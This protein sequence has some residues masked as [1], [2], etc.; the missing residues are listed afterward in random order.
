M[1]HAQIFPLLVFCLIFSS[2]SFFDPLT[3]DKP[4][5]D[6]PEAYSS[7][8]SQREEAEQ[9]WKT[10]NDPELDLLIAQALREN[11]SLKEAWA[12]LRQAQALAVKSGADLYPEVNLNTEIGQGRQR[13]KTDA[14]TSTGSAENYTLGLASTY[15]L[16][17]WGR[18]RSE[19]QAARLSASASREDVRTAAMTLAASVAQ[20]WAG[21]VSMRMQKDLLKKQLQTDRVYLELVE[22]RFRKGMVSAL[23]VYQQKQVVEEIRS[24][25]PLIEEQEQLLL[26]ELALLLGKTASYPVQVSR[27]SLPVPERIPPAGLPADL[28]SMRPD[29]RAAGLRLQAADWDTAAARADRLPAIRLSAT[30]R[31]AADQV[32]MI[33]DN[34]LLS[35]AGNLSAPIFDGQRR[36]AEVERTLA[37]ADEKLWAYRRTVYTAFKEVED[38]LVS[39]EKRRLHIRALELQMNAAKRALEQADERY[40][41]GLSDYLPVLTQIVSVQNLERNLIERRTELLTDRIRLHR[42]LGGSWMKEAEN[43]YKGEKK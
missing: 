29:I 20:R 36:A 26:H 1:K 41:R 18:I 43:G 2:C 19:K 42:A 11:F 17:L 24:R 35:L 7:G 16:D 4:E 22:L 5:G 40:R 21:I 8:S 30:A 31:Y 39:E 3:R 12:R 13:T 37:A 6:I 23:D 32:D 34:W 15:E 10:F 9:W 38:A 25:I 28:L 27:K 33:F 14:G